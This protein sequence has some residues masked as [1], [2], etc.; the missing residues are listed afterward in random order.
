[1]GLVLGRFPYHGLRYPKTDEKPPFQTVEEIERRI[2]AGRLTPAQVKELW[3]CL[4]LRKQEFAD[5][6]AFA[7]ELYFPGEC[8]CHAARLSSLSAVA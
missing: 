4:Y 3:E 1:M 8:R 5:L 6:L 7:K 2:A